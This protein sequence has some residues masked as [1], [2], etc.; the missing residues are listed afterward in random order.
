MW[1]VLVVV[2]A[3]IVMVV[4]IVRWVSV[5]SNGNVSEVLLSVVCAPVQ[6]PQQQ[7]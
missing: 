1:V 7:R 3:E 5:I 2:V 4:V 6:I